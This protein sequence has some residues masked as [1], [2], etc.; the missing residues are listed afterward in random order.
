VFKNKLGLG[1][2]KSIMGINKFEKHNSSAIH[3]SPD[4]KYLSPDKRE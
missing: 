1:K 4:K 3:I 2:D